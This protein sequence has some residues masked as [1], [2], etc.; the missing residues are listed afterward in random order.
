MLRTYSNLD[1][2]RSQTLCYL[3]LLHLEMV[4]SQYTYVRNSQRN[5]KQFIVCVGIF[6]FINMKLMTLFYEKRILLIVVGF[7]CG[8]YMI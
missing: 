1:P 2:H 4:I 5:V 6:Y 8:T 7:G 3:M